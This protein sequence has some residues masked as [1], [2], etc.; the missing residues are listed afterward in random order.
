M[1]QNDKPC[2]GQSFSAY[3]S[4]CKDG[5][6]RT[7]LSAQLNMILLRLVIQERRKGVMQLGEAAAGELYSALFLVSGSIHGPTWMQSIETG[8]VNEIRRGDST[9]SS[10]ELEVSTI[11]SAWTVINLKKLIHATE[12]Q[13]PRLTTGTSFDTFRMRDVCSRRQP[14]CMSRGAF[15]E[16]LRVG[17]HVLPI[18]T[19]CRHFSSFAR[20]FPL[21]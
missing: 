4:A 8:F 5:A 7:L 9:S 16:E 17:S 18:G 10:A 13:A 6:C 2:G 1:L 20:I 21:W 19:A 11:V 12:M 15:L 14:I 3:L